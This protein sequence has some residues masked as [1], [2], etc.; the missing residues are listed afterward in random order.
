MLPSASLTEAE[1]FA[2]AAS[3]QIA[4]DVR[5]DVS[6]CWGAAARDTQTSTGHE[7]IAAA[8]AALLEAKRLGPGRLQLRAP[9]HRARPA[10]VARRRA[11]PP[12]GQRATDDLI[13]R[14]VA[15]LDQIRPPTTLFALELLAA[16]L[17]NA[18]SAAGWT[19][20]VTTDDQT[21]IRAAR[22]VASTL[23]PLSGLRVLG[24]PEDKD[25][26]YPL[27]DYPSTARALAEGSAFVAGVDVSG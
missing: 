25:V 10:G 11:P 9:D 17:S 12:P 16:E 23:N 1:R 15:L 5:P 19:I 24:L 7:L 6:L 22:G 18:L 8:D 20:S 14:F 3:G 4:R 21:A 2:H 27:A 26:L 13:P